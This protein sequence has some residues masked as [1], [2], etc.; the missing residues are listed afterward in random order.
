MAQA[1]GPQLWFADEISAIVGILSD[2]RDPNH[3]EGTIVSD[4]QTRQLGM[5]SL[6]QLQPQ[7]LIIETPGKTTNGYFYDPSRRV[8]V[9]QLEISPRGIEAALPDGERVL[10]I[11]HLDH[12]DKA[13]DD[14]DLVCVGFSAHY[15]AMR[16]E[17][18]EHMID[19]IAGENIIVD[20]PEE[21]WMADLGEKLGIENQETGEMAILEMIESAA[22]C[23]EFSQ[24]CI[25]RQYE[26]IETPQMRQILRF[27]GK[28]RRGFLLVLDQQQGAVTVRPGDRVFTQD[29]SR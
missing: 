8:Q 2:S 10:D 1:T 20:S 25:Q 28:G 4:P 29:G 3:V 19:G 26:K 7:G 9:D 13:Y 21:V 11:H 15:E 12:P 17:F 18:G 14:D 23:P 16:E 24:F 6:V 27:L 22:P 5:V